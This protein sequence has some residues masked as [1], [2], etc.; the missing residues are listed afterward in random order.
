MRGLLCT[1]LF[2][3]VFCGSTL[4]LIRMIGR[5]MQDG[6]LSFGAHMHPDGYGP[7]FGASMIMLPATISV[8]MAW[9]LISIIRDNLLDR[10]LRRNR[11]NRKAK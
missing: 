1:I 5:I 9:V 6:A 11:E 3:V 8:G 10:R 7:V 4:L 2:F